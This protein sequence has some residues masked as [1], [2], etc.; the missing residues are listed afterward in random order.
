MQINPKKTK[1]NQVRESQKKIPISLTLGHFQHQLQE[2]F[3]S[4]EK[5]QKTNLQNSMEQC[6]SSPL[7]LW[8]LKFFFYPQILECPQ[9]INLIFIQNAKQLPNPLEPAIK[10]ILYNL[11][12]KSRPEL[13]STKT[14]TE[15]YSIFI[16][17]VKIFL[18]FHFSDVFVFF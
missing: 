18:V 14:K 12:P 4:R 1:S 15:N 13:K 10:Q 2:C 8:N 3:N 11:E 7:V 9:Q 6:K 16:E 5:N 17:I